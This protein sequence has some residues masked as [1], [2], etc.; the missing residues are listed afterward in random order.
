MA[1][2]SGQNYEDPSVSFGEE[3]EIGR[4]QRELALSGLDTAMMQSREAGQPQML[5]QQ[6]RNLASHGTIEEPYAFKRRTGGEEAAAELDP[7]SPY[8]AL[9]E[10]EFGRKLESLYT[11]NVR[12]KMID[13]ESRLGVADVNAGA[14]RYATDQ[15]RGASDQRGREAAMEEFLNFYLSTLPADEG[16]WDEED[17]E[18]MTPQ[19]DIRG[20]RGRLRTDAGF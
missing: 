4:R 14:S 11:Q 17:D 3:G 2:F 6:Q 18:G 8:G 13:A 16:D 5:R 1:R 9:G 15:R 10:E 19:Q 7:A 12:P 20:I